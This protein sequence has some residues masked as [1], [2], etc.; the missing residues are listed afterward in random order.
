MSEERPPLPPCPFCGDEGDTHDV[1]RTGMGRY[2]VACMG[3]CCGAEGPPRD[4]L[5]EAIEAWSQR[6]CEEKERKKLE[7]VADTLADICAAMSLPTSPAK[8][9]AT[10]MLLNAA[11]TRLEQQRNGARA[12]IAGWLH[13]RS[14]GLQPGADEALVAAAKEL[15]IEPAKEEGE[16]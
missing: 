1:L 9:A 4:T 8:W 14:K 7:K 3:A 10:V 6:P 11:A 5:A 2:Y 12:A 16:E 15:G 13:L